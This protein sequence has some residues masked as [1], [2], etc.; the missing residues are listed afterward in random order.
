MAQWQPVHLIVCAAAASAGAVVAIL[1]LI[2]WLLGSST[3][4]HAAAHDLTTP[5]LGGH[6]AT[7]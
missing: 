5:M 7:P 3:R 1:A 6:L 4:D 2:T